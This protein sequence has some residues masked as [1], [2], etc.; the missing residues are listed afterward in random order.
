MWKFFIAS[1]ILLLTAAAG[2]MGSVEG[3]IVDKK[4]TP[5][6]G[7]EIY[8]YE[9]TKRTP[10]QRPSLDNII[11][12]VKAD[13][14]G[15]FQFV[16]E[17]Q[18]FLLC[19][20]Y[21]VTAGVFTPL[22]I[23]FNCSDGNSKFVGPGKDENIDLGDVSVS[24][25][26][27]ETEIRLRSQDGGPFPDRALSHLWFKISDANYFPIATRQIE[28]SSADRE[29]S[30]I[31]LN[32][33]EG[34]WR[35][36][37]SKDTQPEIWSRSGVVTIP[38]E[39][40]FQPYTAAFSIQDRANDD[41]PPE[42]AKAE[43]KKMMIDYSLESF[44][45]AANSGNERAAQLFLDSNFDLNLVSENKGNVLMAA[46]NYPQI[47]KMLLEKKINVEQRTDEGFT[48]LMFAVIAKNTGSVNLLLKAGANINA[49]TKRSKTAL[50]LAVE[51]DDMEMVEL[52]LKNNA[53][54]NIKN[55]SGKTAFDLA[56][57]S[58]RG[59]LLDILRPAGR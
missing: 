35:F 34:T 5:V 20:T 23:N 29:S 59:R 17:M 1:I 53:D 39:H 45:Q 8:L 19:S 47:V 15:R 58:G 14:S 24:F 11:I 31:R 28:I 22:P 9:A 33:P 18:S 48:P 42:Q 13:A 30:S 37:F 41:L 12:H 38:G 16:R 3:R 57:K 21:P 32:L 56:K 40:S 25:N 55:S 43:L 10:D 36:E 4:G 27:Q 46:S 44:I 54:R 52:L 50:M 51:Q 49:K 7:A 2:V 6:S 26:N